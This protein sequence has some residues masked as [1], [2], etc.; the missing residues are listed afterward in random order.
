MEAFNPYWESERLG[1]THAGCDNDPME[2]YFAVA[3]LF[4]ADLHRVVPELAPRQDWF[5]TDSHTL[6]Y[7]PAVDEK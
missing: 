5:V 6:K 7:V 4:N 1:L 2:P 3:A